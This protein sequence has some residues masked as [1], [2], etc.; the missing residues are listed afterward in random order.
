MVKYQPYNKKT[1]W[2]K[3]ERQYRAGLLTNVEIARENNTSEGLIRYYSRKHGWKKDLTAEMRQKT[4][5][6]LV[7]NL[8]RVFKG[9]EVV[10]DLRAITDEEIIEEASRTQVHVVRDHQSTL[11]RGHKLTLRL[12][13]ELDASTAYKG[14][15]QELISSTAAPKRQEAL[16]R[17]VSLGQ[18][19]VIMRDLAVAAKTWIVLERQAFNIVDETRDRS[20]EQKKMDD[21]TTEQL[22]ES[23]IQDAE[24]LGLELSS[25]ITERKSKA[26][27]SEKVH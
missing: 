2:N 27:G 6:K 10:D 11:G 3:V 4:R 19:C 17:A 1:D 21:M 26:N 20:P 24:K 5:T 22:R 23:I 16:R 15:L 9:N 8:A 7:E 14:E 25:D 13:D 12:L 18:R